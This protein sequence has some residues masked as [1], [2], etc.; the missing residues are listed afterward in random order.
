MKRII[1][2]DKV[3]FI[4]EMQGWFNIHKSINVAHLINK[5]KDQIIWL[6]LDTEK[7]YEKLK[8]KKTLNK[9][10]IEETYHNIIKVIYDT[11]NL[12]F[13][14]GKLKTCSLK[15]GANCV[16]SWKLLQRLKTSNL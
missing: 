15:S 3:E 11:A 8:K 9:V 16:T 1:Y 2:H 4:S 14:D 7:A 5:T 10:G 12:I 13:N 6:P